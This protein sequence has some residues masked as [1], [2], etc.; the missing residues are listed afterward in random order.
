MVLALAFLLLAPS[1]ALYR[2]S[3]HVDLRLVL[4]YSTL[5]SVVTYVLYARDKGKAEAAQWRTPESTL[6][7]AEVLGGWPGAYLAQ[8]KLRHKISKISYLAVFWLIVL[9]YQLVAV[10]FLL[11]WQLSRRAWQLFA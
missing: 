9:L 1:C 2:L 5:I 4:G 10:D 7:L 11:R 8:R 6:H 3:A